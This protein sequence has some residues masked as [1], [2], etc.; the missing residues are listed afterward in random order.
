M[1]HIL[2]RGASMLTFEKP[3]RNKLER[4]HSA[5]AAHTCWFYAVPIS[6]FYSP[7]HLFCAL[8]VGRSLALFFL[9][10]LVLRHPMY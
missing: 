9:W 5:N 2:L 3:I 4:I 8:Q 7:T 10:Q 1:G 6:V